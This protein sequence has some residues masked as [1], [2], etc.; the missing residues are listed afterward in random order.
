MKYHIYRKGS[1]QK[2]FYNM[3][4]AYSTESQAYARMLD[5]MENEYY[6]KTVYQI[7]EGQTY[8]KREMVA[9]CSN[10]IETPRTPPT[11]DGKDPNTGL[12]ISRYYAKKAAKPHH[13]T[14]KV[15]G[16]Y[17]NFAPEEYLIW[18]LQK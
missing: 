9:H 11:K 4:R 8:V 17:R 5:M 15:D 10:T 16:G 14:I 18:R 7:R 13:R 2:R 1:H 6:D 12:Y 3:G